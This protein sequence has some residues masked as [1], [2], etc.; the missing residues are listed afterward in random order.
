MLIFDSLLIAGIQSN[1]KYKLV[2]VTII[3]A[4]HRIEQHSRSQHSDRVTAALGIC[5]PLQKIKK[6]LR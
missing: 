2:F 3:N 1:E 5:F 4:T 6:Y